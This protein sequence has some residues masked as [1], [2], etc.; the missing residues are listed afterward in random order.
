[1]IVVLVTLKYLVQQMLDVPLEAFALSTA[2]EQSKVNFTF[3][4]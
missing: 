3:Q 1:M 4:S 2:A